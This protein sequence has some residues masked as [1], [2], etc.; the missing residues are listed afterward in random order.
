VLQVVPSNQIENHKSKKPAL[1]SWLPERE[2]GFAAERSERARRRRATHDVNLGK[3]GSKRFLP[4][5]GVTEKHFLHVRRYSGDPAV[6]P[7]GALGGAL[8]WEGTT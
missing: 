1:S 4:L 5:L 7:S 2:M 8:G 3:R 6:T